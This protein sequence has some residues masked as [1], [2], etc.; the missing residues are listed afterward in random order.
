MA[1]MFPER[2]PDRVRADRSRRAE[3]RV[4]DAFVK[5]PN[6]WRIFYS[7]AW[8][9]R[10]LSDELRD[11]EA[12]FVVVH[13]RFGLLVLEVK[14]GGIE[15]EG[16]SGEWSSVDHE[17]KV[18]AIHDPFAQASRSK[19]AL[20][21]KIREL[22]AF[23][24]RWV[25]AAHAVVF[26]DLGRLTVPAGVHAPPEI[27]VC[28]DDLGRLPERI[29]EIFRVSR[30]AN[31]Q[32]F[33]AGHAGEIERLLAPTLRVRA[34][35]AVS[36]READ[37]AILTL[38][39]EQYRVLEL[40]SRVRRVAVS[41]P[42]GSGKSLLAVEHARRLAAQGLRTLFVCFNRPLADAV[43]RDVTA[44]DNLRIHTFHDLCHR[45]GEEAGIVAG[46]YVNDPSP[47]F[48]TRL[49]E[50]LLEALQ[51]RPDLRFDAIVVDEG[52]DFE[53]EWWALLELALVDPSAGILYVFHDDA[54]RLTDG[55]STLPVGLTPI[56]LTRNIRNT[57]TISQLASH[58]S[59]GDSESEGPEGRAVE[60]V[61]VA[62]ANQ[63][64]ATL[65]KILHR[66]IREVQFRAEEIAILTGRGRATTVLAGLERIG[67]YR[68]GPLPVLP[69]VVA[70]DTIRR[71]KGLDSRA[72]VLVE[73]DHLTDDHEL[74][75]VGITR[76]R[77]HLVVLATQE[78]IALLQGS[79]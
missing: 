5:A 55:A 52:Q 50:V 22:P 12:D 66:L 77:T 57:Q 76:A 72:V 11:G 59:S 32:A 16:R 64:T 13:P 6:D 68:V 19:H 21:A 61:E 27:V 42:A 73:I 46:D 36:A 65:S 48:F 74:L 54:Q 28:G 58:F 49:P 41:G 18:H 44:Q 56:P 53:S 39:E 67:A 37:R 60:F 34:P 33:D 79:A 31:E 2:L 9:S 45:L 3:V 29:E 43:G 30:P 24:D 47:E 71:F 17:G 62:E 15:R 20:V 40:L 8:L 38:T 51:A 7:V 23:S 4:Y 78:T 63:L 35:L 1:L 75:Y 69:G 14:G 70:V 26:P 10:D 25:P